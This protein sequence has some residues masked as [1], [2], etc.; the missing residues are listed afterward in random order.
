MTRCPAP[1]LP[2]GAR[3]L[4]GGPL[5]ATWRRSRSPFPSSD[6]GA[7]E[8]KGMRGVLPPR[9][10]SRAVPGASPASRPRSPRRDARPRREHP[11]RPRTAAAVP[12]APSLSLSLSRSRPRPRPAAVPALPGPPGDPRC[13]RRQVTAKSPAAAATPINHQ[14]LAD[15]V[16]GRRPTDVS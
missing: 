4:P 12:A 8:D 7:E 14:A 6:P 10:P 13:P 11:R 15:G 9:G 2:Q 3:H 16:D 5:P 1:G